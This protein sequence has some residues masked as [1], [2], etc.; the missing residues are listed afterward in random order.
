MGNALKHWLGFQDKIGRAFMM[1]EDALK[2]PL[3]DYLVN[4]GGLHINSIELEYPLPDFKSRHIDL[5]IT[6]NDNIG[7]KE[8]EKIRSA[9][10]L[11]LAKSNTRTK[12][13]KNR[14][15]SD[16]V[17]MHLTNKH[18]TED[19]YF[20]MVGKGT[21]F[22]RDFQEYSS[23]GNKLFYKK[24][25]EFTEGK[26][27]TFS[28]QDE[29]EFIYKEIYDSFINDYTKCFKKGDILNLPKEIT[30]TC[31]F[32]TAFQHSNTPYMVGIWSVE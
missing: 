11:K 25:F 19:C 27:I 1:N 17:R 20:I 16:L 32:V 24:W 21:N 9:F 15:F 31:K 10:E 14:I 3:S 28:V 12:K 4:S 7:R 2:Y 22:K 5:V 6:N 23:S 26:K 30:T 29:T 18:S 13:E 8:K